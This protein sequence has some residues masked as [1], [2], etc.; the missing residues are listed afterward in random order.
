MSSSTPVYHPPVSQV[1][2]PKRSQTLSIVVLILGIL[3][4]LG[5]AGYGYYE[6]RRTERVLI[7]VRPLRYG[8]QIVAED[9]GTIELPL[10]RPPQ[11]A[12]LTDPQQVIGKW[13]SGDVRPNDL[14]QPSMLLDRAPDRPVYPSGE[15]LTPGLVALPFSTRTIGPLTA[16]DS[17]N[18][19]YNDASGDPSR[20]RDQG[21]TVQ[22]PQPD[23]VLAAAGQGQPYACRLLSGVNVL[24]VDSAKE[25][26]Y[27]ELPPSAAQAI[28][29]IQ[30]AG[31]PLWGER[32]ASSAPPLPPLQRLDPSQIEPSLLQLP[33]APA[34]TA[35]PEVQP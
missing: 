11:L 8:Q 19:G 20:C 13:A 33:L 32:Y 29:A 25:V 15:A 7:A 22:G 3:V 23:P 21:G 5:A 27:L 14:L 17:V 6:Q 26:A 31:L 10:H 2:T 9:L 28:W 18:I 34:A 4:A 16:Q 24:Y 1:L 30:A 35:T 12:G